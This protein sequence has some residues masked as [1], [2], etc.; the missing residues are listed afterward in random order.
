MTF[1]PLMQKVVSA[2]LV[3]ENGS[4][5]ELGNQTWNANGKAASSEEFYRRMGWKNY[6]SLDIIDRWNSL[7]VDLNKRPTKANADLYGCWDLVTNNGTGEHLFN[8]HAVF[9]WMHKLCKVDGLMIHV[10]PW[11]GYINHGFYN[12]NPI[13]YRDIAKANGYVLERMYAGERDGMMM[14]LDD[15]AFHHPKPSKEE[16]T[17]VEQV[18]SEIRKKKGDRANINLVAVLKKNFDAPFKMPLQGKYDEEKKEDFKLF[19]FDVDHPVTVDPFPHLIV[20]NALP[21][22]E[23]EM[24]LKAWPDWR[25]IGGDK[26]NKLYQ[27]GAKKV[28]SLGKPWA[29]FAFNHVSENWAEKLL[30]MFGEYLAPVLSRMPNQMTFGVRNSGEPKDLMMDCQLCVNTPVTE[31][32]RVRGPHV[33]SLDQLVGG[34]FYMPV[35]GDTA[36]GD[37]ILYKWKGEERYVEGKME[38]PDRLVEEFARVPYKPNTL[39]LFANGPDT[40]HGVAERDVTDVPRRYVNFLMNA[41]GPVMPELP[42]R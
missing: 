24:L 32:S 11:G 3:P 28:M 14:V 5:A 20:E 41:N 18:L 13:L 17:K 42:R 33:D 16:M 27:M 40:I 2:I 26:P 21:D 15:D 6:V 9:E 1:N 8:Q 23:Y 34:L 7:P 36:G 39:I 4:V 37:L 12:F 25:E 19:R 35:P 31:K 29:P 38:I 22:K 10:M 30:D